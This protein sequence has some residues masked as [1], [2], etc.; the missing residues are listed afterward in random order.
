MLLLVVDQSV[1]DIEVVVLHL[2][3]PLEFDIEHHQD[4]LKT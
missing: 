4:Q 2:A 3:W 1:L